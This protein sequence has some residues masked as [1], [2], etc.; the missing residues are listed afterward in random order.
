MF[1]ALLGLSQ[2]SLRVLS[3]PLPSSDKTWRTAGVISLPTRR[4]SKTTWQASR[5]HAAPGPK[6]PSKALSAR[7]GLFHFFYSPLS[8]L[9][10]AC[11]QLLHFA[12]SCLHALHQKPDCP[13]HRPVFSP[14]PS[15]TLFLGPISSWQRFPLFPLFPP[16]VID[17]LSA[18]L[19]RANLAQPCLLTLAQSQTIVMS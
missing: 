19:P 12:Q 11:R 14:L 5:V 7:R 2:G 3:G 4:P 17:V 13:S 9:L 15:E 18:P 10:S 1:P 16:L 6:P 8:C